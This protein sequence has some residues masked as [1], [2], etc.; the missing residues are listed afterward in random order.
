LG[1]V[2][3]SF[4]S[5]RST[6]RRGVEV[7]ANEDRVPIRVRDGDACSQRN[8]NVAVSGH[9][10]A[11]SISRQHRFEPL[12][13]I[14]VHYAFWDALMRD[15][16]F[17]GLGFKRQ[18]PVGPHVT[19]IV[20][21]PLKTVLELVAPDEPGAAVSARIERRAWLIDASI[22]AGSALV[23]GGVALFAS[24]P[25]LHELGLLPFPVLLGLVA[26]SGVFL[27]PYFSV[28]RSVV[29]ELVGEEQPRVAQATAFF[30]AA[31][32]LTI[33]L[34]PPLAGVKGQEQSDAVDIDDAQ[35]QE[36]KDDAFKKTGCEGIRARF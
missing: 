11:V 21:F 18:V 30:Q 3:V 32:R 7:D 4:N 16:R 15:K 17:V 12:R 8:E 27:A 36:P 10:N 31:N 1:A 24:I 13:H 28:Q 9:D 23:A 35:I 29:P 2:E 22:Y 34:G 14:E 20:S 6:A 19:D 33:F 26:L 25:L 5:A